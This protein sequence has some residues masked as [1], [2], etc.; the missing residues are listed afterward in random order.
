MT[1]GTAGGTIKVSKPGTPVDGLKIDIPANAYAANVPFKVSYQTVASHTFGKLINILSPL[2]VVENGSVYA[3]DVMEVTIPVK[4]PSDYVVA[5]FYYD[6]V[7]GRLD[8]I[9]PLDVTPDAVILPVTHFSTVGITGVTRATL[10]PAFDTGFRPGVDDWQF[11]NPVTYLD[12]DGCCAGMSISA[13]WYYDIRPDGSGT[14]LNGLYDNNQRKPATPQFWQDDSNAVRLTT[15]LQRVSDKLEKQNILPFRKYYT[16]VLEH[17]TGRIWTWE[18]FRYAMCCNGRPQ[19]IGGWNGGTKLGHVMVAYRY[20]DNDLYVAD[21]NWPG[22][23][24]GGTD[25]KVVFNGKDF[26]A[27]Q[28]ASNAAALKAGKGFTITT[29]AFEPITELISYQDLEKFW[30]EIKNGATGAAL[31]ADCRFPVYQLEWS[32]AKSSPLQVRDGMTTNQSVLKVK[33]DQASGCDLM[34]VYLNGDSAGAGKDLYTLNLKAG[35]NEIGLQVEKWKDSGSYYVDFRR[36]TIKYGNV[37]LQINP[38]SLSGEPNREY[39]FTAV[40]VNAPAKARYEWDFGD[41]TKASGITARHTFKAERAYTITLLM[42]DDARP[43]DAPVKVFGFA[44]IVA[45]QTTTPTLTPTASREFKSMSIFVRGKT[46]YTQTIN[47]KQSTS[48]DVANFGTHSPPGQTFL[49]ITFNGLA[50]S[51]QCEGPVKEGGT[52]TELV[53]G[54]ISADRKTI[55]QLNYRYTK[56]GMTMTCVFN[57]LPLE[58]SKFAT[59]IFQKAGNAANGYIKEYSGVDKLNGISWQTIR[60]TEVNNEHITIAFY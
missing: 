22:N 23:T 3:S 20:S 58:T 56:T 4:V 30:P 19:L 33:V 25:R 37:S 50:F 51:G 11:E 27:Y 29:F 45:K 21:P 8:F 46:T 48:E 18:T 6:N 9:A 52:F 53:E 34:R 44:N 28:S 24:P 26:N 31:P 43:G 2:I 5:G 35:E 57:A 16:N 17:P 1:V 40:A 42:Y 39:S 36:F 12:P 47:N 15:M 41:S 38:E 60:F 10:P 7:R 14:H 49:P 59:A 54:A 55:T 32:D 13:A